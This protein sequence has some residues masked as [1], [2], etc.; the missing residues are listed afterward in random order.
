MSRLLKIFKDD[1]YPYCVTNLQY[2]ILHFQEA[3]VY[4]NNQQKKVNKQKNVPKQCAKTM[5]QNKNDEYDELYIFEKALD[6]ANL[7]VY[8]NKKEN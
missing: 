3:L 5:C 6:T 7:N 2:L 8:A 1:L 4:L